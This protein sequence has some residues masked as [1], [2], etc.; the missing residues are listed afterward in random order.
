MKLS[1]AYG[2]MRE[3][4]HG[5]AKLIAVPLGEGSKAGKNKIRVNEEKKV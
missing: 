5:R 4:A 1:K 2:R 3:E